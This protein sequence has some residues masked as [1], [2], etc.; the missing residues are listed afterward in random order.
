M[1][2]PMEYTNRSFVRKTECSCPQD[3]WVMAILYEQNFGTVYI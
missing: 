2:D 3:I 1:F